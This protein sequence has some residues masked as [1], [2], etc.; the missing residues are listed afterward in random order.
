MSQLQEAEQA[1]DN[2]EFTG[3]EVAIIGMSGRFPGARNLDEFWE[4]LK[5]GVEINMFGTDQE[6]IA[7]GANPELLKD[8]RYVKSKGAVLADIEYFDAAFFGYVPGEAELLHPQTRLFHEITWEVLENAGYDPFVYDGSIGMYAGGGSSFHWEAKAMLAGKAAGSALFGATN[9]MNKDFLSTRVCYKLNLKGPAISINT[10]CSTS[11]VAIDMACRAILTGL[12]NMAIAGGVAIMGFERNG[13]LYEEGMISSPDGRCRAFDARAKGTFGGEGA[14]AV[15]LKLL[16]DALEDGDTIHAVIKGTAINNDG[17]RKVGYTAP[18][19]EG[20]LAVIRESHQMAEVDPDTIGYVETHG[21]GTS[22]GDPVEI[23]ALKQ[24][25]KT[26]KKHYCALGALKTNIGHLDSAAGA[27]GLLKTVLVLK[28]RLIPPTL[29]FESPNPSIDFENSPFFVN[30]RL[31]KWDSNGAPYRAGVSSFGIGGTNAH[32]VLEEAPPLDSS[33]RPSREYQLLLL[34]A[35]TPTALETATRNLSEH[36]QNHPALNLADVAYTLQVG[37][38]SMNYRRIM[39]CKDTADALRLLQSPDEGPVRTHCCETEKPQLVFMFSGLGSQYQNMALELYQKEEVF[40]VEADRCFELLDSLLDFNIRSHL[41]PQLFPGDTNVEP[42]V[43]LFEIAQ[44]EIFI[45]QYALAKLLIHW[46]ISPDAMI[47]YSFGEYTAACI[48]GVFSLADLLTL[49]VRRGKLMR[50]I[51]AGAMM[52]V[53]LPVDQL[54]PLLPENLSLAIDNGPSCIVSGPLDAIETFETQMKQKRLMCMRL[55]AS[56]AIHSYMMADIAGE[57]E[58]A[59]GEIDM[60]PLQIPYISNM[61]ADWIR[62]DDAVKPEYW[63]KHLQETVNYADGFKKLIAQPSTIFLEI[64]PGQDLTALAAR[65]LEESGRKDH[66]VINLL[67]PGA[68]KISD[69]YLLLNRLGQVWLYGKRSGWKSFYA[70]EKRRRIPL[71]TYPFERQRYW[72]ED[73]AISGIRLTSTG[74]ANQAKGSRESFSRMSDWFYL[75]HWSRFLRPQTQAGTSTPETL[76]WLIFSDDLG[77]GEGLIS[78]LLEAGHD[79]VRVAAGERFDDSDPGCFTLRPGEFEDY[80]LLFDALENHTYTFQRIVHLWSLSSEQEPQEVADKDIETALDK[81][82]YSVLYLTKAMTGRGGSGPC[83]LSVI[84]DHMLE[85]SG[86]E[87]IHPGKAPLSG[88]I[89]VI[90]QEYPHIRC[91]LVDVTSS[92]AGRQPDTLLI[93]Q[94]LDEMTGDAVDEPELAV[95][96]ANLWKR[97][98]ETL[99]LEEPEDEEL[100]LVNGGVYL[101]TG[102]LGKIAMTLAEYFARSFNVKLVLLDRTGDSG[103]KAHRLEELGAEVRVEVIDIAGEQ[104]LETIVQRVEAEWGRIRGVLHAAGKTEGASFASLDETDRETCLEQF[105][106]KLY[107]TVALERVF[108]D[109]DL[110]FCLLLS[111]VSTVLGGLRFGPYA[112]AN[113]FMDGFAA[114]VNQRTAARWFSVN[115]DGMS[116]EDTVNGFKRVLALINTGAGRVVVSREGNLED[117]LAKWVKLETLDMEEEPAGAAAKTEYPRPNLLNPYIP[118]VTEVQRRIARVWKGIFG[119][120]EIG[121]QDDFLEL[122][123]DSLKAIT[124][125]SQINKALN[126]EVPLAEFFKSPTIEM[127]AAYIEGAETST[128]ISISPAEEKE[129]YV[130]SSAQNRLYLLQQLDKKSIA[131]NESNFLQVRGELDLDRLQRSLLNMIERHESLRTSIRMLK[132][133]A[134]QV[135]HPAQDVDFSFDILEP[136][137]EGDEEREKAI[138]HQFIQPFDLGIAPFFRVGVIEQAKDRFILIIDIHHIVTDAITHDIFVRELQ[139]MYW[140]L[141]LPQL[142]LQYKDYSEWQQSP[143]QHARRIKQEQYW[144]NRF[145]GANDI[146]VLELPTDYSRPVVLSFEGGIYSF[147]MTEEETNALRKC[148]AGHSATLFMVL[149]SIYYVLLYKLGGQDDIVVGAPVA[150]RRHADLESIIGV[151]INSLPLRNFPSAGKKVVDFLQEVK[152]HTLQ[153]FENQDYAFEDLVDKLGVKRDTGRN[154]LFDV[155]FVSQASKDRTVQPASG[156]GLTIVPYSYKSQT[157]KFDITLEAHEG[158]HALIFSVE[159]SSRLFHSET[160]QR[161][162]DYYKKIAAAFT[163]D[164]TQTLA[165]IDILSQDEKTLLLQSFNAGRT[166]YSADSTIH[167][168]FENRSQRIPGDIALSADGTSMSFG[169]LNDASR[170]FAQRLR[171]EGIGPGHIAALL[172]G[173]SFDMVIGMLAIMKTGAAYMPIDPAYPPERIRF[174]LNDSAARVMVSSQKV[175]EAIDLPGWSGK[176]I[177]IQTPSDPAAASLPPAE[178]PESSGDD[179]CYLIYTSGSTGKPKGALIRHGAFIN[180]VESHYHTFGQGEGC[181]ATQVSSPGF[182]A[183]AFEVWTSLLNG[184]AIYFIPDIIRIDATSLMRW[185]LEN[186]ITGSFQSTAMTRQLLELEWPAQDVSLAYLWTGGDR[187][188]RFPSHDLPFRLFNLY[189]LTEVTVCSTCTEVLPAQHKKNLPSAPTIGKPIANHQVYIL[190]SQLELLPLGVPGELCLGGDCLALG[191]LNRPELTA[192]RFVPYNIPDIPHSNASAAAPGQQHGGETG[193]HTVTLVYRTGDRARWLP[194]GNIQFLGRIDNQVKIR[195]FRIELAEIEAQLLT[196]PRIKETVVLVNADSNGKDSI[197]CA[198]IVFEEKDGE[199][200]LTLLDIKGH[201]SRQLPDYM[202][203]SIVTPLERMPLTANGKIDKKALLSMNASLDSGVQYVP[204][205]NKIEEAIASAWKEVLNIDKVGIHDNFFDVGGNSLMLV[206]VSHKLKELFN[207]DIPVVLLFQY[208]TISALAALIDSGKAAVEENIFDKDQDRETAAVID[209]GKNRMKRFIKKSKE[210]R[211][212]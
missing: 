41:Y 139:S 29:H 123:G 99:I 152:N 9:L 158:D 27:A 154:P 125:I 156:D 142:R 190:G 75:P 128:H 140:D 132:N 80:Q 18:S 206:K 198:Y 83:H 161:F 109:R 119:F 40:R 212:G 169:Q 31:M 30:H 153:D 143:A 211:N 11:L 184:A 43:S 147:T 177:V 66:Q 93:D 47:G 51:P 146:P 84:T 114:Y 180:L 134:V 171:D 48:A 3:L 63:S 129:Y 6:M 183:M 70:D 14:G 79:V 127:L 2:S 150:G 4:N 195:G 102:G 37:R 175:A 209:E 176:T 96:G 71:P 44:L 204:P 145:S 148:A 45:I 149:L 179:A 181:R 94:L 60:K 135:I 205:G 159:Y 130:L 185:L 187:L 17:N 21:T 122:G 118:P 163:A 155:M 165:E 199:P 116:P 74:A 131:Y 64:G 5:N 32:I 112:S 105:Q 52:S 77:V 62:Y 97:S 35:K 76:K 15:L 157:S 182:D 117:R 16:E 87:R 58:Q 22:L 81:G 19:I 172:T 108:R 136:A 186:K 25:F 110:D 46:G 39:V 104:A 167:G 73:D 36:L 203:P 50:T 42:A 88:L 210:D 168:T 141:S 151:F 133:E 54:K 24:G 91:R 188:D 61:T 113:A 69:L 107:G 13:Y 138:I 34:S 89:K 59:V 201:L 8:P 162:C 144:L 33:H 56:H 67:R 38:D 85:V 12:C 196:H 49:I 120:K 68:R 115:W 90:P 95:R 194:D 124:A 202:L 86:D 53:P 1:V 55:T 207:R 78:A 20:Q 82:F 193:A 189:G 178:L 10:A 170:R 106:P 100:P 160:I 166:P 92:P 26:N 98:Y 200:P 101:I 65:H 57:F 111:S 192:E 72:I 191:Y 23:E 137:E 126:V 174:M 208:T 28:H 121:I 197:I 103:E 164:E 173:R 7:A